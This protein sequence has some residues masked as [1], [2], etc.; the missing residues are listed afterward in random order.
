MYTAVWPYIDIVV[1]AYPSSR[2]LDLNTKQNSFHTPTPLLAPK[3]VLPQ[4]RH[5]MVDW[6]AHSGASRKDLPLVK[7]VITAWDLCIFP[8]IRPTFALGLRWNLRTT[9]FW[10]WKCYC[11]TES[12]YL[13][14][15][16]R[17]TQSPSEAVLFLIVM[18]QKPTSVLYGLCR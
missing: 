15:T 13:W 12:W 18:V 2:K 6:L 3:Y 11:T 1:D 5:R 9:S 17:D 8:A 4:L 14:Q 16:T 10:S 7:F